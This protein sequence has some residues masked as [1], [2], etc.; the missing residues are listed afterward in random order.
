MSEHAGLEHGEDERAP[1]VSQVDAQELDD[2]LVGM[3]ASKLTSSLAAL[4]VR[5][6][7][8]RSM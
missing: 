8:C 1:R 6:G 4:S 2:G 3:M 5:Q 7:S